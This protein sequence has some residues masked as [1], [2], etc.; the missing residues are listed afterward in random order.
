M[1]ADHIFFVSKNMNPGSETNA[2][3]NENPV[4]QPAANPAT[5]ENTTSSAPASK[6]ETRVE[7]QKQQPASALPAGAEVE[8][9]NISVVKPKSSVQLGSECNL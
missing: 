6:Q 9:T 5:T 4:A 2:S 8:L 7:E 3:G 1:A